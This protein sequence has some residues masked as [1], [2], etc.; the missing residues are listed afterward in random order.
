M[1]PHWRFKI[2]RTPSKWFYKLDNGA[3]KSGISLTHLRNQVGSTIARTPD[4]QS[5]VAETT[6]AHL[7][8]EERARVCAR[9]MPPLQTMAGNLVKTAAATTLGLLKGQSIITPEALQAK[10]KAICEACEFY[11]A[12]SARCSKCGCYSK[13]KIAI[14]QAA[15]PIRK[16]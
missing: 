7:S 8:T 12:D 16:W 10:R 2:L 13:T 11:V 3:I 14:A 9:V 5:R 6:C 4:F 1:Q 15:C